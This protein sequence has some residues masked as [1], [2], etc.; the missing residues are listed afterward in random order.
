MIRI[1]LPDE[2]HYSSSSMTKFV[3]DPRRSPQPHG[4]V[5][6]MQWEKE[7]FVVEK[8]KELREFFAI[9]LLLLPLKEWLITQTHTH[10]IKLRA[11]ISLQIQTS[12]NQLTWNFSSLSFQ[13]SPH[14]FK[15]FLL[16]CVNLSL[17]FF[18]ATNGR[19][20]FQ[21]WWSEHHIGYISPARVPLTILIQEIIFS[22]ESTHQILCGA[23]IKDQKSM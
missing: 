21:L 16:L 18:A 9:R 7:T 20:A 4:V 13:I 11:G 5:S 14:L 8:K 23:F 15:L 6:C 10:L 17:Y 2:Y 1:Q 22:N 19:F 3:V 12:N